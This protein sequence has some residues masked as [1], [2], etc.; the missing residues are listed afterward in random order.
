MAFRYGSTGLSLTKRFEGKRLDAYQDVAGIWTIGYGHT[1]KDVHPGM[2]ISDAT[3]DALLLS[4]LVDFA[5]NTGRGSLSRSTLLQKFVAG[6]VDGA[7]AS[8]GDWVYAKGVVEPGLVARRKAEQELF[9][10][11]AA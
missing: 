5:F 2:S 8:F 4:D 11:P 7:A 9:A 6:D 10:T 1:G 3:A